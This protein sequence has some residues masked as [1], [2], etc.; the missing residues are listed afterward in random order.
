MICKTCKG[1]K[2]VMGMGMMKESCPDCKGLGVTKSEE[3]SKSKS[4]SE[5]KVT[6]KKYEN[7]EAA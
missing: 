3:L 1:L 4:V 2:K 7:D 6:R 5:K